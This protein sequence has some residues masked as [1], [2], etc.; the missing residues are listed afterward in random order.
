L[1]VLKSDLISFSPTLP[2]SKRESIAKLGMGILNKIAIRFEDTFWEHDFDWIGKVLFSFEFN[3]W[4]YLLFILYY[5]DAFY[6][7]NVM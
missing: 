6:F 5:L 2:L 4:E 7:M 1:G 3:Y